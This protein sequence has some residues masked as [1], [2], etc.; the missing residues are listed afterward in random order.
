MHD[1]DLLLPILVTE[2]TQHIRNEFP[3]TFLIIMLDLCST[4]ITH[5]IF[6]PARFFE[7]NSVFHPSMNYFTLCYVCGKDNNHKL[8]RRFLFQYDG[9]VLKWEDIRIF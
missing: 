4:H 5:W 8:E 3:I 7:K 9:K 2:H 6:N 1:V